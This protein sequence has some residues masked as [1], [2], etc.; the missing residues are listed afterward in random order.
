MQ[1]KGS[2]I[3]LMLDGN[4]D[5]RQGYLASSLHS[6]H[7]R[8]VILECHGHRAPSTYKRNTRNVPIDGIWATPGIQIKAGGYFDFDEV[9]HGTDHR[10]LWIDINYRSAFGADGGAP[11]IR[12]RAR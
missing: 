5:M 10:T 2:H 1:E 7:L 6:V 9:F 11:I 3:I 12:P 8:E 4:Q